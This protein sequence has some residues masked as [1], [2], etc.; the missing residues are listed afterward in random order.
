[1]YAYCVVRMALAVA[2]GVTDFGG[3]G[4]TLLPKRIS[5]LLQSHPNYK[6]SLD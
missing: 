1:M 2:D 5:S 4:K 3:L 6:L